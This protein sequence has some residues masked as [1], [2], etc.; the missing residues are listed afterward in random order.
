[1]TD[2]ERQILENQEATLAALRRLMVYAM[3]PTKIPD[4]QIINGLADNYD[5]TR[6]ILGKD[7]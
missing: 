6:M 2:I 7:W 1:M 3:N 4:R 5:K